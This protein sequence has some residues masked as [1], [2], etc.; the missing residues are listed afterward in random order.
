MLP[1]SNGVKR[2]DLLGSETNGHHLHRLSPT[3]WPASP[4]SL[5]LVDVVASL[6]FVGP[7]LDLF[8][9]RHKKIV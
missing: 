6:G 7:C 9:C 2:G 3:P 4:A 8:V 1:L 5:Q